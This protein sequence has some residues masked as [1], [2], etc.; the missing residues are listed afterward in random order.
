MS[1]FV[2]IGFVIIRGIDFAI[3]IEWT[4]IRMIYYII[5]YFS[6]FSH[7]GAGPGSAYPSPLPAMELHYSSF[8]RSSGY[9]EI[10]SE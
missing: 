8:L 7:Y 2:R 9:F 3:F 5:F 6:S 4:T 10:K 1:H